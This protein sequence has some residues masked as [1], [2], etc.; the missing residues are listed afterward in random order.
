MKKP[1]AIKDFI[2]KNSEALHYEN[3]F[4]IFNL[5]DAAVSKRKYHQ[6]NQ[7]V[8]ACC[9]LMVTKGEVNVTIDSIPYCLR[10]N[11]ALLLEGQHVVDTFYASENCAAHCLMF[12]DDYLE[13][14]VHDEVPP[15]E[16]MTKIWLSPVVE[17]SKAEFA[18][19]HNVVE[20]IYFNLR[21]R[22]HVFLSGMLKNDLRSFYYEIWNFLLQ[23]SAIKSNA[24][25][26]YET[27]AI[28]FIRLLQQNF[29]TRREV[30]YYAC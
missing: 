9:I 1:F 16:L 17:F 28:R 7:P 3:K 20:R 4:A 15:R 2:V 27:T 24:A 19:L 14:L 26:P 18:V 10:E 29:R 21:R 13:M 25:T 23:N 22:D 11:M 6:L 30:A 8:A 12:D 5:F